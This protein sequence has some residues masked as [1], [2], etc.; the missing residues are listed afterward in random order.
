MSYSGDTRHTHSDVGSTPA[1]PQGERLA[2][3]DIHA[4]ILPGFDDGPT[5]I[6]ESLDMLRLAEQDGI[7]R[8]I[9]TPHSAF[10]VGRNYGKEQI[11]AAVAELR[12][13]S[14]EL[15]I[16]VEV[17]PGIESHLTPEVDREVAQGTVFTL[18]GSR[19][20]LLEL[21]FF[22]YPLNAEQ[23]VST[24]RV[25]GLTPILAHP[26][27]FEYFQR[28]PNSLRRLVELGALVQLTADSLDGGFGSRSRATSLAILEHGW[29]HFLASDAHDDIHRVPK[30]SEART[31]AAET[32]GEEAA[33]A[34]VIDNPE[35]VLSNTEIEPG[36]PLRY[37][38]KRRW[39]LQKKP[40]RF[41]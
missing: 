31:I 9:A 22:N 37:Q 3:V 20:L 7:G 17:I 35:A 40:M 38:T 14:D 19:Y 32:I 1:S 12:E 34:L 13:A 8:V 2:M 23:V 4:H 16:R 33:R 29:A 28:E 21:P 10:L 6:E 11:E 41:K 36:E 18:A 15:D 30:L 5:S 26:E 24:L 39:F 25:R 27:R